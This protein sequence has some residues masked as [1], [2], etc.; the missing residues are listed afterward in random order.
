MMKARF[1]MIRKRAHLL[2]RPRRR[3]RL[4]RLYGPDASPRDEC[5]RVEDRLTRSNGTVDRSPCNRKVITITSSH[6]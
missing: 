2:N 3:N 6:E 1:K 5:S 4:G